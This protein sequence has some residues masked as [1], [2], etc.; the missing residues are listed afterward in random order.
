MITHMSRFFCFWYSTI[1]SSSHLTPPFTR[2]PEFS[3]GCY[4]TTRNQVTGVVRTGFE[5]VFTGSEPIAYL[6]AA[7]IIPPPDYILAAPTGFEPVPHAVTGRYCSHSTIEPKFCSLYGNRT[8]DFAVKGRRLN[9]L[10]NRPFFT[11]Y[12]STSLFHQQFLLLKIHHCCV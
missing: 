7:S 4:S 2:H 1:V 3:N 10:S 12:L 11:F 5:P 8:R 6:Y 9:P